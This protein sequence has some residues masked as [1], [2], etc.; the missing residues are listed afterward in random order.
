MNISF[1]LV[2]TAAKYSYC[3]CFW[4]DFDAKKEAAPCVVT[5]SFGYSN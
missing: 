1:L 4:Q 3:E 5:A 2:P